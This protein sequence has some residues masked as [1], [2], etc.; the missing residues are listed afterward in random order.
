MKIIKNMIL[1]LTALNTALLF[2]P[3]WMVIGVPVHVLCC[4]FIA[5]TQKDLI[6]RH[7]FFGV[8]LLPISF[9]VLMMLLNQ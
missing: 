3:Y 8:P 6:T 7:I 5:F 9:W 2:N 1:L 4:V